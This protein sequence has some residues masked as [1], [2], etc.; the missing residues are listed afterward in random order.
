MVG[1]TVLIAVR[2]YSG[3][4]SVA[5]LTLILYADLRKSVG[6]IERLYKVIA[7]SDESHLLSSDLAKLKT[8]GI[9]FQIVKSEKYYL[10]NLK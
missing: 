1:R 2:I 3:M 4:L 5:M 9:P 7:G 6:Q 8:S 10:A